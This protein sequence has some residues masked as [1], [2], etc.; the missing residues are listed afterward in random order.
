MDK[1]PSQKNATR[2]RPGPT[3]AQLTS[4]R[5]GPG[6]GRLQTKVP[7]GVCL[8]PLHTRC[9]RPRTSLQGLPSRGRARILD[10]CFTCLTLHKGQAPVAENASD[11]AQSEA[12]SC[13]HASPFPLGVCK[14]KL[15]AILQRRQLHALGIYTLNL[16]QLP[17]MQPQQPQP[18]SSSSNYPI[19][20]LSNLKQPQAITLNAP[21]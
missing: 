5:C 15:I 17:Y 2:K 18:S 13:A 14:H 11:W 20:N 3:T 1:R 6:T 4:N 19:C 12:I 21:C 7:A 8:S 10:I 9:W 16:E